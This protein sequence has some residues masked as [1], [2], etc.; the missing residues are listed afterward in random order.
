MIHSRTKLTLINALSPK[1]F[2]LTR[3]PGSENVPVEDENFVER[4]EEY[5]VSKHQAV[6]VYGADAT[7][8]A[9]DEA[10]AR[11][12]EAGFTEVYDYSGGAKAWQASGGLL[13]RPPAEPRFR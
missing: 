11:L 9:S 10:A 6:V 8:D 4:V 12:E 3:I 1:Q 5:A 2:E 13:V 7:C